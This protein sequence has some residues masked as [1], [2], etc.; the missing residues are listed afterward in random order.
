MSQGNRV[1]EI[2]M[3]AQSVVSNN[4]IMVSSTCEWCSV[5]SNDQGACVVGARRGE[6]GI[7]TG[8]Y[9]EEKTRKKEIN[10]KHRRNVQCLLHR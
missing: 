1:K 3:S 2:A 8:G 10:E 4:H 7:H 9:Q 6:P 5:V